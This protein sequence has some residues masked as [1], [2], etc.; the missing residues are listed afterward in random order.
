MEGVMEIAIAAAI[1]AVFLCGMMVGA[2]ILYVMM[3]TQ[4]PIAP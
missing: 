3:E 4:P 1:A 2:I